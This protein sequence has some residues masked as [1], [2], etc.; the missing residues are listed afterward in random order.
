MRNTFMTNTVKPFLSF[1]LIWISSPA[2]AAGLLAGA[3]K[4]DIT[5]NDTQWLMGYNARQQNAVHD[6]ISIAYWP[7]MTARRSS[8]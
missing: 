8:T 5:P 3:S 6:G 4:V 7:W 1:A 2:F